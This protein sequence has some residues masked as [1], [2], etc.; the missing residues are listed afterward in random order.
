M[1]EHSNASSRHALLP[2]GSALWAVLSADS[3]QGAA[4]GA[5]SVISTLIGLS[6]M[7]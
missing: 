6:L 1:L 4:M 3:E 5:T 7:A 2:S